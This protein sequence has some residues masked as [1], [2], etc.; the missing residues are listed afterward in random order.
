MSW[1]NV[2]KASEVDNIKA[3]ILN[4]YDDWSDF[5]SELQTKSDAYKNIIDPDIFGMFTGLLN[6]LQT[7][8]E[9]IETIEEKLGGD[10]TE[11][12]KE[13]ALRIFFVE[14]LKHM[15]E[16]DVFSG[17]LFPDFFYEGLNISEPQKLNYDRL[18]RRLEMG[19]GYEE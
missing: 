12:E 18:I 4:Y 17:G 3:I 9:R 10:I 11:E 2:L 7:M 8:K 13:G 5:W 14:R 1:K 16:S 15:R 19:G 6:S